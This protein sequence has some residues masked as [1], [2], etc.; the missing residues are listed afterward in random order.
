MSKIYLVVT[1]DKY[2]LPRFATDTAA[3]MAERLGV[4]RSTV[5]NSIYY[6]K[7]R[8]SGPFKGCRIVRVEVED[9]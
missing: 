9:E 1:A 7:V 3:E 4:R 5:W 8:Q 6:G 2:E